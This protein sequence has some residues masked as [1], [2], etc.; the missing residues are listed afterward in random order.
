MTTGTMTRDRRRDARRP[1]PGTTCAIL[2]LGLALAPAAQAVDASEAE[3]FAVGLNNPRGI[4]IAPNGALYVTEVGNGGTGA[5]AVSP[6]PPPGTLR[7]YGETGAITRIGYHGRLHRVVTGLPS[8]GLPNGQGE[9]GPVDISF[10]GMAA[11]VTFGWGGDPSTRSAFGGKSELFGSM[12]RV[13]PSGRY[14]KVADVTANEVASNPYGGAIDTNPYGLVA[15]PGRRIV[16]DAGSNALVEVL[17]NGTTRTFAVLPAASGGR[18]PVPTSVAQG[19][20]GAIYAGQLTGFP[21]F[22]G[23]STVYRIASDGS[24]V[25][26]FATGFTAV[27]DIT[28]DHGGALYVLEVAL[29]QQPP[30]PPPNPGLGIGRLLRVCPGEEPEELLS[31]LNYPGGVAIG[32]DGAAYVTNNGTSPT[33]GEVLRL[34][35]ERCS[36]GDRKGHGK[37]HRRLFGG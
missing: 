2:L 1:G 33:A 5:C 6:A 32:L 29:G 14:H 9:G 30:F 19:P 12:I 35:L 10:L 7:C 11:Y 16:A 25:E 20:D 26:P 22:T 23:S 13:L 18:E 15:L 8:L 17:P 27:V 31:G 4:D 21:F 36:C 28:F 24:S 3:Q 37:K 34:P